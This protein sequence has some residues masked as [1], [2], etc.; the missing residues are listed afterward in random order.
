MHVYILSDYW[1]GG[2]AE[3]SCIPYQLDTLIYFPYYIFQ[4]YVEINTS[5][6]VQRKVN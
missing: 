6:Y 4:K 3:A 1:T 5:D 2:A